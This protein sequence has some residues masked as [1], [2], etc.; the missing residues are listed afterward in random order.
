M[1]LV[2]GYFWDSVV[3]ISS[4]QFVLSTLSAMHKYVCIKQENVCLLSLFRGAWFCDPGTWISG[5]WVECFVLSSLTIKM[6]E[7]LLVV[8]TYFG[9][10]YAT[11][12]DLAGVKKPLISHLAWFSLLPPD[13]ALCLMQGGSQ[14]RSWIFSCPLCRVTFHRGPHMGREVA[15]KVKVSKGEN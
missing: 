13:C 4:H 1:V 10:T 6:T 8:V 7:I 2:S 11:T 12:P 15:S 5:K 3:S 14:Q 9:D